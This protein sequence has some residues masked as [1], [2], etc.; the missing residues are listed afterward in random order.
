MRKFFLTTTMIVA[1]SSSALAWDG[2]QVGNGNVQGVDNTAPVQGQYTNVMP[3]INPQFNL[4]PS[5]SVTGGNTSSKSNSNSKATVVNNVSGGG[6]NGSG[7]GNISNKYVVPPSSPTAPN[8]YGGANP[9]SGVGASVA[10]TTPLFGLSAGG[11]QLDPVCQAVLFLHDEEAA[12]EI[13]CAKNSDFRNAEI[14]LGRPCVDDR[15]KAPRP[16]VIPVVQNVPLVVPP[17]VHPTWCKKSHP[18]TDASKQ[19]FHEQ[20]D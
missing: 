3:N 17:K 20:C 18:S 11:N 19:Y 10:G 14:K 1:L 16:E 6:G 7:G 4:S 13:M 2:K 8:I 12:K 5:N 9:C 15:T